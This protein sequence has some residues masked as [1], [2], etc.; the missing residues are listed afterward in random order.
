MRDPRQRKRNTLFDV[1]TQEGNLPSGPLSRLQRGNNV[2]PQRAVQSK[3]DSCSLL[4]QGDV[5]ASSTGLR[6]GCLQTIGAAGETLNPTCIRPSMRPNRCSPS[7]L[8]NRVIECPQTRNP[9]PA[10]PSPPSTPNHS[11]LSFIPNAT[12][13]LRH[14]TT[15]R[16][17]HA[18]T[19]GVGRQRLRRS[20]PNEPC[21]WPSPYKWRF[22]CTST[23]DTTRW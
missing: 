19:D 1:D 9:P 14:T 13:T 12:D 20:I 7:T 11:P 21:T 4:E 6:H 16:P 17:S 8:R 10:L 5:T 22:P 15:M 2:K 18:C 23:T 3:S